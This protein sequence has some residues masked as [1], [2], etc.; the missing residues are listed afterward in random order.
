MTNDR[1]EVLAEFFYS[2]D[3]SRDVPLRLSINCGQVCG[4]DLEIDSFIELMKILATSVNIKK[5]L[6]QFLKELGW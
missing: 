4:L 5:D 3:S 2:S 1:I 6:A